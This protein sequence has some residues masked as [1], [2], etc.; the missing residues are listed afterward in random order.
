MDI[1]HHGV[2]GLIGLTVAESLDFG[3]GG[4]FFLIGSILPDLDVFLMLFGKR[5]YLKNHQGFSHSLVFLPLFSL[6]ITMLLI[7]F[8]PFAWSNVFAIALGIMI[9]VLLDYS[10]TYG[11]SLLYPISKKRF[12]L[13][14]VFFI[15]TF[16]FVLSVSVLFLK[17]HFALYI[18]LFLLYVA[19]KILLQR[20]V[21]QKLHADFTIPSALNP[22]D[23]YIYKNTNGQILTYQYNALTQKKRN[24]KEQNNIDND[25]SH[26]IHKSQIYKD[27]EQITKALH[28]T[29][30]TATSDTITV[31]AKD[32][33]LRNFG[34]KFATTTLVFNKE[35]ELLNEISNI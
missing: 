1:V 13:D 16:L 14:S 32:L 12:S 17:Y 23:F 20:A 8:I 7:P 6:L 3:M 24:Y 21:H 19:F 10:N 35:E 2:I 5:V 11:I 4:M 27:I 15:D 26:L 33:A 34:G 9:H 28:I 25:Y 29:D 18:T 22:F 30:V 31:N